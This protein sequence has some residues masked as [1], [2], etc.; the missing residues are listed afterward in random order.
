[1]VFA[2]R[3]D[4]LATSRNV[5]PRGDDSVVVTVEALLALGA[6][7]REKTSSSERTRAERLS[8]FKNP[9]RDENKLTRTFP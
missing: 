1:M 8:D 5:T 9:R 3:P 7:A 4:C 6:R 2:L